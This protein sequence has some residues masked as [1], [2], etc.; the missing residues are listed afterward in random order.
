[1]QARRFFYVFVFKPKFIRGKF[2]NAWLHRYSLLELSAATKR[3]AI[4]SA[5]KP[6][7]ELTPIETAM[8]ALYVE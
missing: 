2:G 1:M 5:T 7:N 6:Y 4:T 8:T 3:A